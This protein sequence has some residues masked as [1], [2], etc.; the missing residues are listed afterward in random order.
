MVKSADQEH[1]TDISADAGGSILR[2]TGGKLV[3]PT[4]NVM[5]LVDALKETLAQFRT[6]DTKYVDTQL[7]GAEKL[8]NYARTAE[9]RLREIELAAESRLRDSLRSADSSLAA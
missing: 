4:Q 1:E 5:D 8:Q 7:T 6:A 9:S 2:S 3:D